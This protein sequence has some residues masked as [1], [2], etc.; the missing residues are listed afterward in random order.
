MVS[1]SISTSNRSVK[2]STKSGNIPDQ[3]SNSGERYPGVKF[4]SMEQEGRDSSRDPDAAIGNNRSSPKA[5]ATANH[6]S[7]STQEGQPLLG[8]QTRASHRSLGPST[9][10]ERFPVDYEGEQ[11][12]LFGVR[13]KYRVFTDNSRVVLNV[14][15]IINTVWLVTKFVSDFFLTIG[16]LRCSNRLTSFN[17]L[18]LIFISIM[19][20]ALNL[21]FNKIGLYSP[22]DQSLN[23]ILVLYTVFDLLLELMVSYTRRRIG[24]VGSFTYLWAALTFLVGAV[25]DW[26]LFSFIRD[27]NPIQQDEEEEA[28]NM[29][30]ESGSR[31]TLKEWISI[32]TRNVAKGLILLYFVLFTFNSLLYAFDIVRVTSSVRDLS[33]EAS[34]SYDAFHWVDKEKTYQLHI[35]CYGDILAEE[36]D[37]QP[38]ILFE[39]G[40]ADTGFLSATWIQELYH[41]N[42]V[43][44]Y[45]TYERPGY[46][47]SD[48]APAPISIAMVADA[49]KYALLTDA[50]IKGPFTTVGYD[51]GGLFTQ[52]FTAKNIDVV[53][54]MLLVESWHEDLLLKNYLQRILPPD[55]DNNDPDDLSHL[56]PEIRR[57]NGFIL[58]WQGIWSTLGIKL[59]T[60]WLLAHHGSKERIFGRDMMYQSRYLR[61]KFLESVTSSLLSYKDVLNSKEKLKDVKLSVASSNELIKKSPQWGNWQRDLTKL[62]SKTQEWKVLHGG[63]EVYKFG[64]AKQELQDVLLR[65]IEEKDRY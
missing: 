34:A 63:H 1:K 45:C 17:D 32:G 28:E 9:A 21:W 19:A 52:V 62:S 14:L 51:L 46:G 41:L 38:I 11:E 61:A 12:H 24:F 33:A 47:L 15:I 40:G 49:L 7:D 43:Q 27:F 26:Y 23:I 50:K 22:I 48:S 20:N 29:R 44:R 35:A 53:D 64:T 55:H 59:Q 56:P 5:N 42:R 8:T 16:F 37:Q 57:H 4:K 18:T 54:S 39:H 13:K 10:T 25:L 36:K 58:W 65:L 3:E 2:S 30:S 6:A 60:S 31:H